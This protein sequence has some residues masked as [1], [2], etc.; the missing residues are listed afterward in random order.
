MQREQL[1]ADIPRLRRS[2]RLLTGD[3]ARADDLV[4]AVLARAC[5]KWHQFRPGSDLRAW[6]FSIMHNLNVNQW[7]ERATEPL[8]TVP[9]AEASVDPIPGVDTLLDL[10]HALQQLSIE[11]REVLVLICVEN[12]SYAAAADVLQLPMGTIMSRLSRARAQLR[13]RLDPSAPVS[14]VRPN[15]RVLK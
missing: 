13:E 14:S 3:P 6:L 4:Q 8:A 12:L 7:R 10:R 9:M 5:E 2:A 15:L 11:H 1:I